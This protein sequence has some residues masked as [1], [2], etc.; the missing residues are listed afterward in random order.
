VCKFVMNCLYLYSIIKSKIENLKY[1]FENLKLLPELLQDQKS[2]KYTSLFPHIITVMYI[3]KEKKTSNYIGF[4]V[5]EP[6]MGSSH[7][8]PNRYQFG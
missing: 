5:W 3:I 8:L 1:K 7:R 2:R 4:T 6:S